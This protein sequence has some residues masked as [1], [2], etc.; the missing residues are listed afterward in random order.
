MN[1]DYCKYENTL[2]ALQQCARDWKTKLSSDTEIKAK[3]AL[4]DLMAQLLENDGYE[5][6]EPED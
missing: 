1:M 2:R 3:R 5:I 4:I 6:E